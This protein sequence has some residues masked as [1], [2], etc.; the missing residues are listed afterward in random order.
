MTVSH[1]ASGEMLIHRGLVLLEKHGPSPSCVTKT[2]CVR[3][4]VPAAAEAAMDL[5][6]TALFAVKRSSAPKC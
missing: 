5:V 4:V 2:S 6:S 1:Y 3:T